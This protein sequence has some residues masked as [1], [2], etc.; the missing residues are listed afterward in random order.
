MLAFS[1]ATPAVSIAD[2]RCTD[3]PFAHMLNWENAHKN[4]RP[5]VALY[6]DIGGFSFDPAR[7]KKNPALLGSC[8]FD[9][10]N[11]GDYGVVI[12]YDDKFKEFTVV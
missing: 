1:S 11:L 6:A 5:H 8:D 7:K 2:R 4:R 9:A 3:A 10:L 12:Y